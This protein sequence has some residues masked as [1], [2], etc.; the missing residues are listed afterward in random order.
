MDD[1]RDRVEKYYNFIKEF[2]FKIYVFV[3]VIINFLDIYVMSVGKVLGGVFRCK[4]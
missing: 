2:G 4:K 3:Q 1:Q